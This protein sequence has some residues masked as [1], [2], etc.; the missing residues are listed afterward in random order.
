MDTV[1]TRPAAI[2]LQSNGNHQAE[3]RACRAEL[4]SSWN[5]Q[6]LFEVRCQMIQ[7]FFRCGTAHF[8][9]DVGIKMTLIILCSL[10]NTFIPSSMLK[11]FLMHVDEGY[12]MPEVSWLTSIKHPSSN[13]PGQIFKKFSPAF[14]HKTEHSTALA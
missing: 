9:I 4:K 1:I 6:L 11:P 14:C 7:K 12:S 8:E 5:Y 3:S 2:L 13:P 10:F